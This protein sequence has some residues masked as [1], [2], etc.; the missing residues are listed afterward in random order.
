[1][2]Q[3][4]ALAWDHSNHRTIRAAN[5]LKERI[6]SP[7]FGMVSALECDG[8]SVF[9]TE[10]AD[11]FRRSYELPGAPAVVLGTLFNRNCA[12]NDDT[13]PS[14]AVFDAE[15]AR[16]VVSS[17]GRLL[18][19]SYW[20]WY[21]AFI[22][23]EDRRGKY[24]LRGPMGDLPCFYVECEGIYV[25]FSSPED[26]VRL[27]LKRLSINWTYLRFQ[28]GFGHSSRLA[29]SAIN[30][31]EVLE[32]GECL[33][34]NRAVVDKLV[35]WNPCDIATKNVITD[36]E[37]AARAL[38]AVTRSCVRAW[39]SVH[40]SILVRLSGGLDSSVLASCLCDCPNR[41]RVTFV[42]YF[43]PAARG[44]E[45]RYVRALA[46]QLG[47]TVLER[48]FGMDGRLDVVGNVGLTAAPV[49][50]IFDW[51]ENA[52][53]FSIAR[54]ASATAVFMGSLGDCL[55][56]KD[57]LMS[58]ASDYLRFRGFDAGFFRVAFDVAFHDRCSIW[59][60]FAYALKHGWLRHPRGNWNKYT[61]LLEKEIIP[62]ESM[63][64]SD[65][66]IAELR[67]NLN[68]LVHSWVSK[69]DDVPEGKLWLISALCGEGWYDSHFRGPDDPPV[70]APYISQPL[71][72]LC[73]R[74]PTY[75]NVRRAWDRA[76]M[77][78]AF[79]SDLPAEI[80]RRS[81]KGTPTPWLKEVLTRNAPFIREFLL[82]GMLAR[83]GILDRRKLE[84]ALPGNV[85]KSGVHGG[86]IMSLLYSESWVRRWSRACTA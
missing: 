37:A 30:E 24:V 13:T 12:L 66:V 31:I 59:S 67:S 20:G 35:Y 26:C 23:D 25:F 28:A 68:W 73:L 86:V 41:P 65:A 75:L 85:S 21:V 1:M 52:N 19:E 74:I 81:T 72:E 57:T 82:D 38:R 27:D 62:V 8:L 10:K 51:Q 56:E 42:N 71:V 55:F 15:G 18:T 69:V 29:E 79:A 34:F 5:A 22:S 3:Y 14:E 9:H 44:D 78:R 36:F 6:R 63:L 50:D 54:E 76:T 40:K 11:T 39:T 43:W 58:P 2:F 70:V 61:V 48:Q 53:D 64:A 60:V 83:E 77:R 49:H 80:V 33:R 46:R 7:L 17:G 32:R 84:M 4:I 47:I 16:A 45:R